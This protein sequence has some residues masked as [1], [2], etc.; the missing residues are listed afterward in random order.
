MSNQTEQNVTMEVEKKEPLDSTESTE[1]T[2]S[3]QPAEE[4]NLTIGLLTNIKN[5][6][7]VAI[8]RGAYLPNEV[9]TVGKLYDQYSAALTK[10][11]EQVVANQKNTETSN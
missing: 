4:N 2:E 7:E 5:L 6:V 3:T 11:N 8:K 1:S 10:L 9:S